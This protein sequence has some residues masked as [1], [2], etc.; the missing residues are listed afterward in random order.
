ML[1]VFEL[2][3]RLFNEF[4][5][6]FL[7]RVK[8]TFI[9]RKEVGVLVKHIAIDEKDLGFDSR[10]GQIGRSCQRLAIAA[11]FLRSCVPRRYT[12]KMVLATRYSLQ[13]NTA[14]I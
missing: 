8:Y 6:F 7:L 12:K 9:K 5:D 13:R 14:S 3:N 2:S 4:D 10:V 11:T 1:I